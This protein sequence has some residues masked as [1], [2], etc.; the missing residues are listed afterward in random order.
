MWVTY[1]RGPECNIVMNECSSASSPPNKVRKFIT[2]RWRAANYSS[3]HFLTSTEGCKLPQKQKRRK[4]FSSIHG[5]LFGR[6]Q[7]L[8]ESTQLCNYRYPVLVTARY[9][10]YRLQIPS[11]TWSRFTVMCEVCSLGYTEVVVWME[12]RSARTVVSLSPD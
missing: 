3:C 9:D 1:M 10:I 5:G 2:R 6:H 8:G 4:E 12:L 7:L 11:F